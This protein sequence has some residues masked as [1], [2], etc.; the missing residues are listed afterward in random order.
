MFHFH[1]RSVKAYPQGGK[2]TM[3]VLPEVLG[4]SYTHATLVR[5]SFLNFLG[6]VL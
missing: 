6:K 3:R 4:L 2:A 1:R 5:N